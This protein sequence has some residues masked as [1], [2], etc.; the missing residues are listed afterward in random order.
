M[1]K[2]DNVFV[3]SIET[4]AEQSATKKQRIFSECSSDNADVAVVG[5]RAGIWTTRHAKRKSFVRKTEFCHLDFEEINQ[6]RKHSFTFGNGQSTGWKRYTRHRPTPERGYFFRRLHAMCVKNFRKPNPIGEFEIGEKQALVGSDAN[7]WTNFFEYRLDRGLELKAF[8]IVNASIFDIKTIEIFSVPLFEPAD[9]I[10]ESMDIARMAWSKF[11]A[12]VF[13]N[14]LAKCIETHGVNCVFEACY[15][16]IRTVS[17]IPLDLD[18]C[19]SDREHILR[20][21]ESEPFGEG[22]K[23]LGSTRCHAHAATRQH[24]VSKNFSVLVNN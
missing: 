12:E 19:R 16:S 4:I 22:R 11:L 21:N 6:P 14:L 13:L 7:S 8:D 3:Q 23:G 1:F 17:E 2:G 15:F 20:R 5:S 10:V 18:Y 9:V 24:V